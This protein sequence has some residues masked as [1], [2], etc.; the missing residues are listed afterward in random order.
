[1][2]HYYNDIKCINCGRITDERNIFNKCPEC[3]KKGYAVN[4]SVEYDYNK[5]ERDINW[6]ISGKGIWKYKSFFAIKGEIEPVTLM[7]GDTPLIH[8]KKL[9][10]YLKLNNLYIKDETRN[11]TW[12]Y[13]DRLC[14]V[15]VTRAIQNGA[16]VITAS[17]T[18]NHGASAAAYAAAAGL[19]CVVFTTPDI[20]QTMK[21]LMKSYGA[22]VVTVPKP[23]DRWKVMRESVKKFGWFHVSGYESPAI[24][25][26]PYGIAGYKTITF[27]IYETLNMMP[28]FIVAP[29]AYGDGLYGMWKGV[30]ELNKLNITTS[31]PTMIASEAFGSYKE[32][33]ANNELKPVS[34]N[35]ES[36]TSKSFS[37]ATKRGTFQGLTALRE[38][39]G[40]AEVSNDS[41]TMKMQKLLSSKEGIFA[42]A[43]SLTPLVAI[44]KLREKGEI[45]ENES[46]VAIITST[47]LK[48]I[49]STSELTSKVDT[50][51]P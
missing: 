34:L 10:E 7:E 50:I 29:T 38:S 48:D 49:E 15:A 46:V 4:Y 45:D 43:A 20:P 39:N 3:T 35:L 9:G 2:I 25:S 33:L 12:S 17:S 16:K 11:P 37:I 21:T 40:L 1:M 32:S 26:N 6:P 14:S 8:V 19:K 18:G 51:N 22:I 44:S 13:K 5:L 36:I 47:G 30:K 31:H 42:E 28:D 41:E 23:E 24:G 27:E